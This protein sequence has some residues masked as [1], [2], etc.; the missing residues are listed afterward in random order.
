LFPVNLVVVQREIEISLYGRFPPRKVATTSSVDQSRKN[1]AST[2]QIPKNPMPRYRRHPRRTGDD[3]GAIAFDS[4]RERLRVLAC[5]S[6]PVRMF[7]CFDQWALCRPDSFLV[8]SGQFGIG[9]K[10]NRNLSYYGRFPP[11]KVT[12]TSS[13][14]QSRKNFAS[15][16]QIPKNPMPRYRKHPG[17][18]VIGEPS[19]S[20]LVES[21]SG[22]WLA[23]RHLCACSLVSTP[24]R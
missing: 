15:T 1:F 14:D 13:V 21:D 4:R 8:V 23:P 17:E 3:W 18:P 16:I 6:T 5:A 9:P 11:R 2:I 7:S 10:R 22:S 12:T 19:P 20:T 24:D